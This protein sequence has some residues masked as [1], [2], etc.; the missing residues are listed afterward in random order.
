MGIWAARFEGLSRE[1]AVKYQP[2][3]PMILAAN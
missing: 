3:P 1:S 2:Q